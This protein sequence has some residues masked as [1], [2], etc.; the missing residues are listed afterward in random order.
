L[1]VR[2]LEFRE[3]LKNE[4]VFWDERFGKIKRNV[5]QKNTLIYGLPWN[6]GFF[7]KLIEGCQNV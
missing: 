6:S 7:W 3:A 5:Y 1:V 2:D 4:M